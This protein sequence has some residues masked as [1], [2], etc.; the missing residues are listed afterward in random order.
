[1]NKKNSKKEASNQ[2][3]KLW[4]GR[5]S[6][7][8][9]EIL[10]IFN[11]SFSFDYRLWRE[12][13]QGSKAHAEMLAKVGVISKEDFK[14]ILEGLDKIAKEIETDEKAWYEKNKGQE[15]IHMAI[16]SQLTELIGEPARR[17]HTGRSRNDQV[18]TDIRLWLR[19]ENH[20]T[21]QHILELLKTLITLAERDAEQILP[22]YTHLQRA[23]P[24]SLGH[25]WMA[26]F[27]RFKRDLQRFAEISVRVN[28]NPLGSGALAG[29][30]YPLDR[31]FTTKKLGFASATQNSLDAV[32]DRDFIAEHQFASSLLMVHLS[33]LSEELILWSSDEFSFIKLDDR[34]ATG[35]SMMPQK[36][37]PDVPELIRGKSGRV[38]G[39]LQAI[40]VTLKGLPLAYNKDL[41]EDKEG[42]FD[43]CSNLK[44]CLQIMSAFLESIKINSQRMTEAAIKGFMNATDAADYLVKKNIPFREAYKAVG[45]A[46]KFC[47]EN[48]K[49]LQDLTVTEWKS[50][51]KNF[52]EDLNEAI[53]I[54]NCL[55]NRKTLGGTSPT[56]VREGIP[57]ARAYINYLQQ[58][59]DD[60][61]KPET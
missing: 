5:S 7:P 42:L 49:L 6:Q 27:E 2:S 51:H 20:I 19:K 9:E 22:G 10:D 48:E 35:S 11:S 38:I 47:I 55:E 21:R 14:Q 61:R 31:E 1:M 54:Q 43:T 8:T 40:L 3:T 37:N 25:H 41:Q 13:I 12:D 46:V 57:S 30:T 59:L 26:H 4:A 36:K 23:Q 50:F 28:I 44:I 39:N 58:I 24:I 29:T 15:D 52:D 60:E 34:F 16:E 17:L 33:Q 56:K 45:G 32:S 53:K 18:A